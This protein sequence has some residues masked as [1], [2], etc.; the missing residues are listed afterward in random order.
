VPTLVHHRHRRAGP[1][2]APTRPVHH[3]HRRGRLTTGA[4]D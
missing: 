3:R 1:P 2:P 4:G